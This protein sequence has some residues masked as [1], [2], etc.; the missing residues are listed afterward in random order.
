MTDRCGKKP[1][2]RLTLRSLS[3]VARMPRLE[4]LRSSRRF[5]DSPIW[6]YSKV[7][8]PFPS[9]SRLHPTLYT[10]IR[11]TSGAGRDAFSQLHGGRTS[12]TAFFCE[13]HLCR[14]FPRGVASLLNSIESRFYYITRV[15][16]AT[17]RWTK[18]MRSKGWLAL[19]RAFSTVFQ[20]CSSNFNPED[21]TKGEPTVLFLHFVP[22]T[23]MLR[24]NFTHFSWW[25][26]S[27]RLNDINVTELP[28]TYSYISVKLQALRLKITL[29]VVIICEK[30]ATVGILQL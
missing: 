22:E 8:F 15:S 20:T 4:V 12:W 9:S 6:T 2:N 3:R 21:R 25:P 19:S 23:K 26:N 30:L 5:A 28:S 29:P 10:K 7:A 16:W 1:A 14:I 17:M 13:A 11:R 24:P 27:T 18:A